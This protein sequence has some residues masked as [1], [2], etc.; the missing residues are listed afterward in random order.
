MK[1]CNSVKEVLK[2]ADK[3]LSHPN[4]WCKCSWQKRS[5]CCLE[6]AINYAAS[7]DYYEYTELS[8]KALDKVC[9]YTGG[10]SGLSFNDETDTSFKEFFH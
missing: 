10:M 3:R 7:G 2:R 5:R 4:A 8:K 9:K 6:G 1:K